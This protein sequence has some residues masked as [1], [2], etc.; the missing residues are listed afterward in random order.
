M[1]LKLVGSTRASLTLLYASRHTT[2]R[3]APTSKRFYASPSFSRADNPLA[4]AAIY[5]LGAIGVSSLLYA[6][7]DAYDGWRNTFPEEVRLPLKRGI[8]AKNAGDADASA[9]YKREAWTAARSLPISAF[10]P[11]GPY[12]TLTGIAIDLAGELEEAGDTPGAYALYTDALDKL[13]NAAGLSP[14]ERLRGVGIALKLGWLVEQSQISGTDKLKLDVS[15]EEEEGLRVWAVEEVLKVV[16]E[17]QQ[18]ATGKKADVVDFANLQL[19]QGMSKTDVCVPLVKLGDFY[20]QNGKAEYA[21]PLYLQAATLLVANG[22]PSVPRNDLCHGARMMNT[23]AELVTRTQPTP[24]G[25]I[26][27]EKWTARSLGVLKVA[28]GK[29]KSAEDD[30]SCETA[31]AVTLINAGMLREMAGDGKQAREFLSAAMKQAKAIGLEE[32]VTEIQNAIDRV[33]Q[34]A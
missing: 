24:D 19:P 6:G 14:Q 28:Q 34:K 13:R 9:A 8:A 2:R 16:L 23:I 5:A 7:Y 20:S 22:G 29:A 10:R 26:A 1:N 30:G 21:M 12:L 32:G 25:L 11:P 3:T 27:A 31:L 15:K 17:M 18:R 33:S 4:K